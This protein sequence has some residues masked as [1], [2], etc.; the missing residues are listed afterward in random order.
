[1]N[2]RSGPVRH[3]D[4]QEFGNK[5][6]EPDYRYGSDQVAAVNPDRPD[7]G[8]NQRPKF[9]GPAW[10]QNQEG[11]KPWEDQK[12]LTY[13]AMLDGPCSYHTT[14]FRKPANHTTR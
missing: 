3:N 14:D 2:N 12:P 7:L 8:S 5:R 11:K 6:R 4:R 13:E 10:G 9:N 1:M